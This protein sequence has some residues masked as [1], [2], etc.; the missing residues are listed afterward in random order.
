VSQREAWKNQDTASNDAVIA[1]EFDSF[2]SDG[3]RHVGKPAA[4]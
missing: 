2:W 3:T 1:D 4:K